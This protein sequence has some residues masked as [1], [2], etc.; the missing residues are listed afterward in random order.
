MR[1]IAARR[2]SYPSPTAFVMPRRKMNGVVTGAVLK[3]VSTCLVADV[4]K[5][6]AVRN[7]FG[8]IRVSGTEEHTMSIRKNIVTF[9]A[10]HSGYDLPPM[11]GVAQQQFT[12]SLLV[13]AIASVA[14][15]MFNLFHFIVA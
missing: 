11:S 2:D 5:R 15:I 8:F 12:M 4:C 7:L 14:F 9:D 6:T 3:L 1:E 13:L 10:H